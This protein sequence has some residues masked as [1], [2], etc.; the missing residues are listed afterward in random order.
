MK[1]IDGGEWKLLMTDRFALR[2]DIRGDDLKSVGAF[3]E[4]LLD[5]IHA[6]LKGDLVDI[7]LSIRVFGNEEEFRQWASCREIEAGEWFYDSRGHEVALH[8]GP[9]TDINRFCGN[10][11]RGVVHVYM[12]RASGG[13]TADSNALAERFA[14]YEVIKGRV[15]PRAA[16][17]GADV[18]AEPSR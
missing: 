15:V 8:F 2:G 10:L 12:D 16:E 11:M 4:S 13:L 18:R 9:T 14:N 7:R 3:S 6:E 17:A 1:S 5:A